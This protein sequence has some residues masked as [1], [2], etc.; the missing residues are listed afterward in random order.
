M[1][2]FVCLFVFQK[3]AKQGATAKFT[4]V[5]HFTVRMGKYQGAQIKKTKTWNHLVLSAQVQ[6]FTLMHVSSLPTSRL[7][8]IIAK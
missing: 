4:G 2:K 5:T 1:N 3:C 8:F 7:P 6:N